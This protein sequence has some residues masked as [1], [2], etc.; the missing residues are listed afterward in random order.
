VDADGGSGKDTSGAGGAGGIK[1][2]GEADETASETANDSRFSSSRI[3]SRRRTSRAL[4]I[5]DAFKIRPDTRSWIGGG[6]H[7]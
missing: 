6:L 7:K 2:S 1:R 5:G 3:R 4:V